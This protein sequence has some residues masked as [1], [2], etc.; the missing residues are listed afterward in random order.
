MK[1][2]DASG[3]TVAYDTEGSGLHADDG[4]RISAVSCAFRDPAT[5]DIRSFAVPFDQGA[6][7]LTLPLGPKQLPSSHARRIAKWDPDLL[8]APNR[9]LKVWDY[10]HRWLL[11]QHLVMHHAKHDCL[12]A[13][14]GLR[15]HPDSGFDL[16]PHVISDTM[17]IAGVLWPRDPVALKTL[18]VTHHWGKELGIEEGA[19]ADE[20]E[21][22]G[23]W[24]GPQNDPRYDLIPWSVLEAYSRQDAEL[25]LI[26]FEHESAL[27]DPADQ[28]QQVNISDDI[29]LARCLY[30]MERR[31]VGLDVPGMRAET[32]KLAAR[33]R[34]AAQLVP[35]KG[36]T[37]AP[38]P[39]A[40]V[41]WF[42]SDPPDGLGLIPY[43]DKMTKGGRTRGPQPQVDEETI[44]RLIKV[45]AQGAREYA[46]YAELKAGMEKWYMPWPDLAGPDGR[47]RTSHKQ[48]FVVSG[49]LSVERWQAQAMPHDYQIPEG[50]TP[51]R[52][53]LVTD[54][55]YEAWEADASQAEIRVATCVAKE[56][57]MLRALKLGVDSHDAAT[58]LMFFQD[59][60]VAEA[61]ALPIWEQRRQVAKRCNLGILYGI[62]KKELRVQIAKF[63]GIEYSVDQCG[64][65]I[66]DWKQAF[67]AFARALYQYADMAQ[68]QGF[69]RLSTGRVRRFSEWEPVHKAFNQRIQGEVA[70]GA[71][72]TMI[73]FDQQYPDMLLLQIHD[74]IVAE[75]EKAR[76]EEVTK[77]MQDILVATFSQMFPPVPFKADCKP[78]GR[79][80][81]EKAA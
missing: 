51:P 52:Y 49:R 47:I 19:E 24:K 6:D 41:K 17:L 42:F 29:R 62:G 48:G 75:M 67:P 12:Q 40:A 33:V 30:R 77:A 73:R 13:A 3:L 37:G 5:S 63:T 39:P 32:T 10:L 66:N 31:G 8:K 7:F 26:A 79:L 23:P 35:F 56:A 59:R 22:L 46:A 50:I 21:A 9:S 68:S 70:E 81:Y 65:W 1:L 78:F 76:V 57:N 45:D 69:V 61:K 15:D 2:P 38:T 55:G 43:S 16:M 28:A 80:A 4:A 25:T 58:K 74:S 34:E 54:D 53:F 72:R 36:G 60:S 71:K 18:A 14:A 27:I 20:Q 44:D 11:R 64:E